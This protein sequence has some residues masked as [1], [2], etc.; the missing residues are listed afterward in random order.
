MVD[1]PVDRHVRRSGSDYAIGFLQLLPYGQAWPRHAYSTLVQAVNGLA[2]YWGFVDGRAAD[3]LEIESDPRATTEMILDWER[4]WGIPD[5]CI[6]HPPTD[7]ISRRIQLV[8]KMTLLG[9]QSR[10]W[11]IDVAA[12]FGYTITITE[13]APY[14]CGVSRCGDRRGIYNPDDPTRFYWHL[15]PREMRYYWTVHVDAA[16]FMKFYVASS[17][18]GTDRL[19]AIFG[20]DDLIC[21]L[22]RWKPAHT[23]IVWDFSPNQALDFTHSSN[24]QYLPLG[25]M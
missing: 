13:Y 23:H 22:E 11:F 2:N 19:L 4:N 17:R 7:L 21:I 16:R 15:G 3:L 9:A 14:M 18:T 1:Q 12:K 10:Q 6:Q 8:E 20:P 24:T 25:I 5:P